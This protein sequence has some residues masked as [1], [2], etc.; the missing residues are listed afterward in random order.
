MYIA[1]DIDLVQI[2]IKSG[3]DEY[4]L[5][6]NVNWRDR[7]ID[8]LLIVTA[9]ELA[10]LGDILSPI[11]GKTPVLTS[12]VVDNLYLDLYAADD[13]QICR[14][15]QAANLYHLNNNPLPIG[16]KLSLNLSRLFFSQAPETDGCIL[17]YFY[18]GGKHEDTPLV[19]ESVTVS[20]P[21]TANGKMSLQEIVDNYIYM[22]PKSVKGV[23]MWE[24][25][26]APAYLTLRYADNIHV[27][28]NIY[29][30]LC[31][32]PLHEGATTDQFTQTQPLMLDNIDI[33]MLNSY[34]QNAQNTVV[35][36]KI[37]FLY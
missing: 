1:N 17:L 14:N 6:K 30:S 8:K 34:V 5:P 10:T 33:D 31:R 35:N 4:Y 26:T 7:V 27:L 3:V 24:W 18:Y 25:E 32:P 2:N 29:S 20:V 19:R 23:Y 21:L 12:A 22:Q 13:T 36:V 37:T 16:Y 28:N 9:P 15:L 11:D